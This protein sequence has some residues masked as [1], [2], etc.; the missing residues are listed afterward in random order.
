MRWYLRASVVLALSLWC[1]GCSKANAGGEG[2]QLYDAACARCHG[3]GGA[4]GEGPGG[5]LSRDLSDPGWQQSVNDQELRTL[6]QQGRGQMP[7]FSDALSL[8][9][10]D[11][12]VKHI[13]TLRRPEAGANTNAK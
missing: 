5:A 13:R 12:I 3:T 2:A 11:K 1:T 8:D 9:K 4:G 7:A 6:I 10:I